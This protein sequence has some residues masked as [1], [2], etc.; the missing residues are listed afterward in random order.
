M[1]PKTQSTQAFRR[2]N[3]MGAETARYLGVTL[4]TRRLTWSAHVNQKGRK[5]AQKL[6]TLSPLLNRRSGLPIRKGVLLYR[7]FSVPW[8]TTRARSGGP[9]LTPTLIN[10]KCCNPS[11]FALRLTHPGTW[12]TGRL[13]SIWGF[14]SS[15]TT[16][17]HWLRALTRI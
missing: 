1:H 9:L 10:Y 14:H 11:V 13:T 5:A 15:T 3:T 17:E 7:H 16:S 6:G 4:D 8:W 12:V 2:A